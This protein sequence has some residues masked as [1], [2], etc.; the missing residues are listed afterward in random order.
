MEEEEEA[1]T[2]VDAST[3]IATD[4]VDADYTT[5]LA[6]PAQII[7]DCTMLSAPACSTTVRIRPQTK[8]DHHGRNSC[9][10]L[11]RIMSKT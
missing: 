1:H 8:Q 5:T 11:V 6:Q 4:E 10:M 3:A 7:E 9:N 2:A